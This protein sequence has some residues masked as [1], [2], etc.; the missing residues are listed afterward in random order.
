VA[1]RTW[2]PGTDDVPEPLAMAEDIVRD[3][4]ADTH[5]TGDALGS[6]QSVGWVHCMS[7][8][9]DDPIARLSE[10]LGIAPAHRAV[11][12]MSGTSSQSLALGAAQRIAAGEL[13]VA[14]VV[15]AEALATK[16]AL[17][18]AGERP[19]W[20]HRA[21]GSSMPPFEWPFHPSEIAHELF[22]AYR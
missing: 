7:W 17:K 13:D 14:V 6:V 9:Y 18:K 2:R 4:V 5:A 11:S 1:Q 19:A 15:G 21:E 22:Q 16:R 12:G 3:A 10:R 20:S 8:P